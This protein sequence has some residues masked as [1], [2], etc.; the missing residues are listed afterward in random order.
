[1]LGEFGVEIPS[2]SY[3]SQ[4]YS[5]VPG[6]SGQKIS[7]P[8]NSSN[9]NL[10]PQHTSHLSGLIDIPKQYLSSIA[11]NSQSISRSCPSYWSYQII[12]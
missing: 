4:Q 9:S 10:M 11:S 1:M 5:F 12:L 7:I 2:C 6:S 8:S 3:I